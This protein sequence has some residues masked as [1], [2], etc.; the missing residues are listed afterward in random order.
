M[1]E[2]G[3]RSNFFINSWDE[4]LN[5]GLMIFKIFIARLFQFL[6]LKFLIK[7]GKRVQ[8]KAKI[9]ILYEILTGAPTIVLPI[10]FILSPKGNMGSKN[11]FCKINLVLF[12]L[13]YFILFFTPFLI[14]YSEVR[15]F[16]KRKRIQKI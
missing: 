14:F 16:R 10:A 7:F 5:I 13:Y 9:Y 11:I 1:Y 4:L 8:K 12:T 15:F 6:P 2:H 3:F